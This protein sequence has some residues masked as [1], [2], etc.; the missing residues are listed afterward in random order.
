M[1]LDIS[2]SA[3]CEIEQPVVGSLILSTLRGAND[4]DILEDDILREGS[5]TNCFVGEGGVELR[6]WTAEAMD[7]RTGLPTPE[8]LELSSHSLPCIS[9]DTFP[10]GKTEGRRKLSS[11]STGIRTRLSPQP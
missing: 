3:V 7:T 2:S 10:Q 5:L 8:L 11:P 4:S 1:E 6:R 9:E